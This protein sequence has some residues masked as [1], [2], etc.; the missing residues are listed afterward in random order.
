MKTEKFKIPATV[1]NNN[2]NNNTVTITI[3]MLMVMGDRGGVVG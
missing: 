1:Q 3:V 2:N